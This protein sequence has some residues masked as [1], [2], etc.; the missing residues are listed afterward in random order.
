[1]TGASYY[2]DN[3]YNAVQHKRS[4]RYEILLNYIRLHHKE[5]EDLFREV[6]TYDYYLRE[7]A[8]SRPEFAGDYLV[9]KNVAR[10]FYEKKKRHICTFRIMENTT[11][12]RCVK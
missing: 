7:N 11:E 9:E 1:M 12:I 8:K 2:E 5:K 4:A 10:A 6:L 3:G